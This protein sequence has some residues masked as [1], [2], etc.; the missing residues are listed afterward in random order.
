MKIIKNSWG[1]IV[2]GLMFVASGTV[3]Q[4]LPEPAAK[5]IAK[6]I[7]NLTKRGEAVMRVIGLKVYDIRLWTGNK[8]HS[9]DEP[10]ALEFL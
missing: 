10:F 7:P 6:E 3:A 2:V 9:Y 4:T 1:L 5:D 8:L